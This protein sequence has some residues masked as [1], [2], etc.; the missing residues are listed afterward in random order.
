[1]RSLEALLENPETSSWQPLL[2]TGQNG[3]WAGL[4]SPCLRY[5]YY[6]LFG[7]LLPRPGPDLFPVVEGPLGGRWV[8]ISYS[9]AVFSCSP[10]AE[11]NERLVENVCA[12]QPA[13]T[14]RSM[15]QWRNS[16]GGVMFRMS[17]RRNAARALGRFPPLPAT[18]TAPLERL[19]G[20]SR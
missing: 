15:I 12:S 4:M 17:H 13:S 1:M 3:A 10:A 7:G 8:D 20:K 19:P 9:L 2:K 18:F 11:V 16:R 6:L 5:D 14:T